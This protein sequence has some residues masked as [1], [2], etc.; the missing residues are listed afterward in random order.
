MVAPKSKGRHVMG[1]AVLS[2]IRGIPNSLPI[3]ATSSIG[4]GTSFGFGSVSPK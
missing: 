4:N 2:T 1:A 3:D